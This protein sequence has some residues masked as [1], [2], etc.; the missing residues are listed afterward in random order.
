MLLPWMRFAARVLLGANATEVADALD[1]AHG[2]GIVH[3]DLGSGT[4]LLG[5][6][7]F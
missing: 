6:G 4:F 7:M 1:D 5:S 3:R 2:R